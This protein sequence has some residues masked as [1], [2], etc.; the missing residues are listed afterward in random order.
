MHV[1]THAFTQGN[2]NVLF[3]LVDNEW[4]VD[5][6]LGKR[7]VGSSCAISKFNSSASL[8]EDVTVSKRMQ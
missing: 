5:V 8:E 3:A 4:S 7:L 6:D 2:I 1:N